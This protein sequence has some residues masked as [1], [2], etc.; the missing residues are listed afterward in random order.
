MSLRTLLFAEQNAEQDKS[1]KSRLENENVF[2]IKRF[3]FALS[4]LYKLHIQKTVV[5]TTDYYLPEL[6]PLINSS[7]GIGK[8][9]NGR[10]FFGSHSQ[11]YSAL[12]SHCCQS[13][14]AI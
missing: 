3:C 13:V 7:F 5:Y 6:R 11:Y 1:I 9:K 12:C 14:S 8:N 2:S 10:H 4:G